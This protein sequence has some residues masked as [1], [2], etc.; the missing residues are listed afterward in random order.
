VRTG[1]KDLALQ[2]MRRGSSRFHCQRWL[3]DMRLATLIR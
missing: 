1:L 3:A 2:A